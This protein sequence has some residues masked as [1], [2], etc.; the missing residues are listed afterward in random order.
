MSSRIIATI[1][2]AGLFAL[3]ASSGITMAADGANAGKAKP[4]KAAPKSDAKP[5]D[6][7][8]QAAGPKLDM[9]EAPAKN[10]GKDRDMRHCLDL[11][12]PKEVIKCSEQK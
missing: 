1:A 3:G 7:G 2:T 6:T 9:G 5:Q 4:A 12:T 8:T 11:P 10:P